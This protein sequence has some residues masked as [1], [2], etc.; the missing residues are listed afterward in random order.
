[1]P[2]NINVNISA[3][4]L[5]TALLFIVIL[6]FVVT[7]RGLILL[8]V[9]GYILAIALT[10][11]VGWLKKIKIPRSIG[12]II[13]IILFV[14]VFGIIIGLIIPVLIHQLNALYEARFEI[15]DSFDSF[16]GT[17]PSTVQES[18]HN[19]V[20]D[21]PQKIGDYVVGTDILKSAFGF[22]AGFGGIILFLVITAYILIEGSS[23]INIVKKY[24]PK[25]SQATAV[26]AFKA[27]EMKVSQWVRSQLIL[28][29]AIGLL[30]YIG[31]LILGVPYAALL[32]VIAAIT[33]LIPYVGPWIG[34]FFGVII[35]FT[36]SPLLGLWT[37]LL[38][39]GIQ[40]F[41][42]AVLVPR[43]MKKTIGLSPVATLFIVTAGVAVLGVLG[44]IIA[45]PVSAG[46]LAALNVVLR[47]LDG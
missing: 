16:I 13:A 27:F 33:E 4:S 38:Y 29:V 25:K 44:A 20:N 24:W 8:F 23:P 47:R 18:A 28:S 32:A 12:S 7:L 14:L 5:L 11:F 34:A 9:L 3:R 39:L 35:A 45:I 41:E 17:L 42:G 19:Y 2:K 26:D 10:P 46:T 1:M 40:Q 22:L 31:L 43:V 15:F 36:V 21:L 6:Y 37:G 30:T